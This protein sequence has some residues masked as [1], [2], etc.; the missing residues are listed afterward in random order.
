MSDDI[1]AL[2]AIRR[3][4]ARL[5]AELVTTPLRAL[6]ADDPLWDDAARDGTTVLLKEELFQRTGSFKP[7]G[8]LCVMRDLP[9]ALLARGV[10]CA[11]GGNHAIA[12]AFAA[13]RLGVPATVVMPA[14]APRVRIERCRAY[15]ATV[16]L[17]DGMAAVFARAEALA[18]HQERA[19]VHPY[20][21]PRTAL[22]TATL[23]LEL[24]EQ[25]GGALDAVI[26]PVGGGGLLAGIAAAV[27]QL[28]P[29]CLV[30]GVEPSGA[31]LMTR[32]L[33]AGAPQSLP[34]A[35]SICDSLTAPHARPYSFALCR[36]FADGV[37]RVDDAAIAEAL[38]RLFAVAKLAVEPAAA[39]PLAA[40]SG[41][42]RER[43][44]GRRVALV[45]SGAN[46]DPD[47]YARHLAGAAATAAAAS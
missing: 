15:G 45:V 43:L 29:R 22:G 9:P 33:A 16:E 3:A 41:P 14:A 23:G 12:T 19:L 13:Q 2:D 26:V 28:D 25:A 40:L 7:R 8:A 36:R 5:A 37:V 6:A 32:S 10:V 31:D 27:K 24:W 39:A 34:T 21:G 42:L 1:P 47:T 17:E 18:A 4:Q 46:L 11:S 20:E 30:F 38:R 44:R 35:Q